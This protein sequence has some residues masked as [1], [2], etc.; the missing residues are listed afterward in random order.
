MSLI[1]TILE[2][3]VAL[4]PVPVIF[5]VNMDRRQQWSIISLLCLGVLVTMLGMVRTWIVWESLIAS[6]DATWWGGPHWTVSE[7]ENNVAIVR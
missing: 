6:D 7:V 3:V 4:L 2:L 5:N 1:N